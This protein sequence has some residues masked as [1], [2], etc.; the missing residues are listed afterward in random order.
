MNSRNRLPEKFVQ[1]LRNGDAEAAR[2]FLHQGVD[3]DAKVSRKGVLELIPPRADGLKCLLIKAGA[4]HPGLKQSL[5][6]ACNQ[7]DPELVKALIDYGA[8]VNQ[9]AR[10]GTPLMAAVGTGCLETF[11]LLLQA[12]ADPSLGTT[13]AT[14]LSKAVVK[15][16]IAMVNRL[17]EVGCDPNL[18]PKYGGVTALHTA[19]VEDKRDCM[20]RL[21]ERGADPNM[22]AASVMTG[23]PCEP[24]AT[25][26]DCSPLHLALYAGQTHLIPRLLEHGAD[27]AV[28]DGSGRTVDDLA[29]DLGILL[30]GVRE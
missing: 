1:A 8:D 13:L 27:R 22:K 6:W 30:P 14:P 3:L 18:T 29:R 25:H 23:D 17:L 19:I 12:G 28:K 9:R 4:R 11:E 20:M 5:V 24:L 16:R 10:S 26:T 21:L 7:G 15:D 2:V